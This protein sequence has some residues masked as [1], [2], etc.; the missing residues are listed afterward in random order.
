M[1]G[2][3][4]QF[5]QQPATERKRILTNI[6]GLEIWEEY[7]ERAADKRKS[8]ENDLGA[9]NAR[10]EEI[11]AELDQADARRLRLTQDSSPIGTI[12]PVAPIQGSIGYYLA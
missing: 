2:K 7:R 11:R 9:E 3:A 6:L 12:F 4:D 10:L 1:Q 5:A 8:L